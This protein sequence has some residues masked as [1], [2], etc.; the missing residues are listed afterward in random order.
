M[1]SNFHAKPKGRKTPDAKEEKERTLLGFLPPQV[2]ECRS[3]PLFPFLFAKVER[4]VGGTFGPFVCR[5]SDSSFLGALLLTG[6]WQWAGGVE[7]SKSR[8]SHR[9]LDTFTSTKTHLSQRAYFLESFRLQERAIGSPKCY[10]ATIFK[11]KDEKRYLLWLLIFH[12]P[13]PKRVGSDDDDEKR[14][15]FPSFTLPPCKLGWGGASLF[16]Q[17]RKRPL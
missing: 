5:P 10:C 14:G 7:E 15:Y 1:I 11:L 8:G 12:A 2:Q 6:H 3:L 13:F 4:V 16:A 17:N 9:T